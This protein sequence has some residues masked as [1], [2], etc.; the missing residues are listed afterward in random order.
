MTTIPDLAASKALELVNNFK[1]DRCLLMMQAVDWKWA[2]GNEFRQPT[3]DEMKNKCFGL[4][5]EA[6]RME[7][8]TST[9]GFE[10]RYERRGDKV[11]LSLRFVGWQNWANYDII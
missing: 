1:F 7:T 3:V 10:A 8:V 6:E 4:L 9:G 11:T 2:I 5:L